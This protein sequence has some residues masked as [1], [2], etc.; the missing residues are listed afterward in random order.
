MSLT[1]IFD[2]VLA[3]SEPDLFLASDIFP[4]PV[5]DSFEAALIR[6]GHPRFALGGLIPQADNINWARIPQ[7][8]ITFP[9]PYDDRTDSILYSFLAQERRYKSK[10][11]GVWPDT[12]A[13]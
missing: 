11:L 10:V 2:A 7:P 9:T 13:F 12:N 8:P 4:R 5:T 1:P 6:A 3:D